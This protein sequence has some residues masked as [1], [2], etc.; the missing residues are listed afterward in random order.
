MVYCSISWYI[1]TQQTQALALANNL[2]TV[3]V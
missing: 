2:V 3:V 1:Y